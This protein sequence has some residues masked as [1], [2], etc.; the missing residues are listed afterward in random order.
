MQSN[1]ERRIALQLGCDHTEYGTYVLG[2]ISQRTVWAI[3]VG[4]DRGSPSLAA[5]GDKSFPNEDALLAIE[6]GDRVVLAVAD[7]HFGRESSHDLLRDLAVKLVTV[8]GTSEE[9][10]GLLQELAEQEP[11][12]PQRSATTLV[13]GVYDRAAREGFGVSFGDSTFAVVGESGQQ[14]TVETRGSYYVTPAHPAGLQPELADWFSFSAGAND[15]LLAYTDGIDE[16]H[17]CRPETSITP[18]IMARLWRETGSDPEAYVRRLVELA[19]SGVD[20]NPGGQDNI[21]VVAARA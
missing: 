7:A 21:A 10:A 8:P 3:S 20:E 5:K 11:G 18:E 14:R 13:V 17:Y 16:C 2:R 15:L 4:A 9:L 1:A 6:Q 19:L 12:P